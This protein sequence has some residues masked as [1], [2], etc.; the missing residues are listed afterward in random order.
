MAPSRLDHRSGGG[1]LVDGEIVEDHGL[2]GPQGRDQD[3]GDEGIEALPIDRTIELEA[4]PSPVGVRVASNVTACQ[5]PRGT[6]PVSRAPRGDRP[7]SGVSVVGVWVSSRKMR[8]PGSTLAI[9]C[10][11][12]ARASASCS[13]AIRDFFERQ[14]PCPQVSTHRRDA[15]PRAVAGLP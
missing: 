15:D 8:L 2:A 10:R 14:P 9:A 4:G 11:H 7:R 13:R 6:R 5:R 12:A 1:T 3:A